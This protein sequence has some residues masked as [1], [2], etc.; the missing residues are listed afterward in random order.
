MSV[1]VTNPLDIKCPKNICQS[2]IIRKNA[3]TLVYRQPRV[4]LPGIGESTVVEGKTFDVPQE[5]SKLLPPDT[6]S[7]NGWF[8]LLTDMFHFENIGFSHVDD[9]QKY[10]SCADCDLAP[11]G[12][13][14]TT[15]VNANEKEYLIAINRVAYI[16]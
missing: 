4:P 14:D 13:H 1:V 12:Y 7:V 8:W 5:I 10:L 6:E 3:A 9:G 15:V 11:L 2:K 16:K